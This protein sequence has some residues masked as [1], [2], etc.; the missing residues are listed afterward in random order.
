MKFKLIIK[1]KSGALHYKGDVT[2][3]GP[4]INYA[5]EFTKRAV[6]H[7]LEHQITNPDQIVTNLRKLK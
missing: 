5:Q 3:E 2:F 7:C 4:S 6:A 1:I